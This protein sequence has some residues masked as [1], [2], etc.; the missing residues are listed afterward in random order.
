[1]AN[2]EIAFG[3]SLSEQAKREIIVESFRTACL[4]LL[5]IFWFSAFNSRRMAAYVT[6]DPSCEHFFK[7]NPGI[8]ISAHLG[9]WE[10][11]AQAVAF[12]GHPCLSVVAPLNNPFVSGVMNRFRRMTGQQL[13]EKRGAIK[14]LITRLREGGKVALVLDQ[15]TSPREGGAFVPFFGLEVPVSNVVALLSSHTGADI[16]F[17]YCVVEKKGV[18]RICSL[19][20]LCVEDMIEP[21][22]DI[23]CA[24]A[25]LTEKAVREHPGQWLW[26]YKRWK[27]M[28]ADAPRERYPFYARRFE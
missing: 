12:H 10:V 5:D 19:P 27:Y 4:V 25:A 28:P 17:T 20:P 21:S 13:K 15:N 26:I 16:V 1:M 8:I 24:I 3:S 9:N 7:A 22:K 14:S 11:M 6:M 18:Y 2:I 23:T